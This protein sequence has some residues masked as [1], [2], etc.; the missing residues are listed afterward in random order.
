MNKTKGELGELL[1]L[2]YLK[3]KRYKIIETNF[4]CKLGEIDLIALHRKTI[5]FIEVKA[6]SSVDY[7]YPSEAVDERKI[8]KITNTAEYYLLK[9][10]QYENFDKRIDVIEVF[11]NAN[12]KINHIECIT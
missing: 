4:R 3:K 9:H 8:R 2:K 5:V 10:Y 6:R 7:G 12:D 1:A 11:L